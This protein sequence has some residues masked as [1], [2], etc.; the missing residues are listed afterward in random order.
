ME[1]AFPQVCLRRERKEE[2]AL[3]KPR[4]EDGRALQAE[5]RAS[6]KSWTEASG[7]L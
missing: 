7:R 4:L 2:E 5:D 3:G 6:L 1:D